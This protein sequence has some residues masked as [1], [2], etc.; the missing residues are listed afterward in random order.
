MDTAFVSAAVSPMSAG[1]C[2]RSRKAGSA[3]NWPCGP[4]LFGLVME[5]SNSCARIGGHADAVDA[6]ERD[7]R[8]NRP[9]VDGFLGAQAGGFVGSELPAWA[10]RRTELAF[11]FFRRDP[12][13]AC[14]PKRAVRPGRPQPFALRP[15]AAFWRRVGGR[16]PGPR[17]VAKAPPAS[18]P[19]SPRRQ[20]AENKRR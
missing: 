1:T 19:L 20:R 6:A 9:W 18:H 10:G 17:R 16:R 2:P 4:R 14:G 13:P 8:S 15:K 11:G 12:S 7:R 3:D 5:R